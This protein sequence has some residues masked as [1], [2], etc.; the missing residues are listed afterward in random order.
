MA[1]IALANVIIVQIQISLFGNCYAGMSQ[2]LAQSENVHTIHQASFSE[3]IPQTMRR[4]LF[5]QSGAN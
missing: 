5:I 3:I 2:Q 1:L 4:K